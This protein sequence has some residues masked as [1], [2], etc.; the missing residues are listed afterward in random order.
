[1][2]RLIMAVYRG[3]RHSCSYIIFECRKPNIDDDNIV[4]IERCIEYDV[5]AET[6]T[7][8]NS[9]NF[10]AN[11]SL[12]GNDDPVATKLLHSARE[13][14]DPNGKWP[15]T[16]PLNATFWDRLTYISSADPSLLSF[17]KLYET[18][19]LRLQ[20]ERL[21]LVRHKIFVI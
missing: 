13:L 21:P 2:M 19:V 20:I 5:H 7:I 17:Y 12:A 3:K 8:F 1:M 15:L 10:Y 16:A 4:I 6:F 14:Y 11:I 9:H 18:Q